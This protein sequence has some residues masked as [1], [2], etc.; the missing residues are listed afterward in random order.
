MHITSTGRR[1]WSR[2]RGFT[3]VELLVVMAIIAVLVG[4]LVPAIYWARLAAMQFRITTEIANM[5]KGIEA[6]KQQ[7]GDY[8]PNFDN[9]A[10]LQ[11][12]LA[13]R[14]RISSTQVTALTSFVVGGSD[15]DMS[16]AEALVFW[17]G[18]Q[19]SNGGLR[20]NPV[21]P[22]QP[23]SGPGEN[24]VFFEFDQGR[25]TDSDGNGW[26]EYTA[27]GTNGAPYVYFEN[28]SY[29]N[30]VG[31]NAFTVPDRGKIGPLGASTPANTFQMPTKFQIISTGLDGLFGDGSATVFPDGPFQQNDRDNLSNFS[32]GRTFQDS[33]P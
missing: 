18:G 9:A 29:S 11:R 25:L 17:L 2:S 20:N 28:R 21:A 16:P 15:E 3:L 6:Y 10:L 26:F 4:L 32:A 12:H 27:P 8:P 19:S 5:E 14:Q 33:V 24:M 7:F 1:A 22:F 13:K 30:F 23:A 31:P